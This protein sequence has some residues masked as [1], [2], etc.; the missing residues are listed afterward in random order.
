MNM[1]ITV[2]G[3]G[4]VGLANAVMLSLNHEVTILD[5][6]ESK[7]EMINNRISPI[8]DS[9]IELVFKEK[10]YRLNATTDKVSAYKDA[11]LIIIATPTDYDE[12][13][14]SFNTESVT[15]VVNDIL[16]VQKHCKILIKSTIPVGFTK[17]L[18]TQ[19]CYDN[20]YFSPEFLKEGNA[21]NDCLN[22]SRIIVGFEVNYDE[23]NSIAELL[24][25]GVYNKDVP[26][27]ITGTSEAEAIKLF[28]NA[29]LASRIAF[30]NE[31]DTFAESK[32]LNSKDII[33]GVCSDPR[34]GNYYNNP[35]F[36][37]GG[38]CL[39]KDTKQLSSNFHNIPNEIISSVVSSNETRINF[40]SRSIINKINKNQTVGVY[41]LTMKTNS[42]NYR[43]SS[44][45]KV[46]ENLIDNGI[47]VIIYEPICHEEMLFGSKI[48]KDLREFKQKSD[49]IIANRY[50]KE[51]EDIKDKL[52]SR[53]IFHID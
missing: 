32:C 27:L 8:S 44:I 53:D 5:I 42:D 46:I 23:A 47:N 51:I 28:S 52:Y 29:Y 25:E 43:N 18:I 10:C 37:Y 21:L 50:S 33:S 49:L 35:S 15:N 22:P 38:Y 48:I 41:R 19:T 7:V 6:N 26:I 4:Y 34:I 40:I 17:Q 2:V 45:L 11:E 31:L 30:F 36:G 1:K 16:N 12:S 13:K 20:I 39:P 3:I 24:K 14:K 9:L